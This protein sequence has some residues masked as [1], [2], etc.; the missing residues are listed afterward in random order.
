MSTYSI[1]VVAAAALALA[2]AAGAVRAQA[3]PSSGQAVAADDPQTFC[4]QKLGGQV[5]ARTELYFGMSRA[6][7]ADVTEEEFAHF[8][9]TEITPRFPDGLTVVSA[10]GQFRGSSGVVIKEPAKVLI[11]FY[12]WNRT[13]NR[14]VERIRWRY[15]RTFAQESVLR[16]D[17]ASCVSF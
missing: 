17:D 4:E 13:R 3:E 9:D 2:L 1:R 11:L 12:S 8:L 5:W 14:A 7:G 15:K 6:Q 16:V 10:D